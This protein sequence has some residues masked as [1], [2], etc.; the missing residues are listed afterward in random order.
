MPKLVPELSDAA[1]RRLRHRGKKSAV[2]AVGG[3]VGLLLVCKPPP[4]GQDIGARSW[5]LRAK[6]GDKRRDLGLGG[7][8]DVT[9]SQARQR[10]RETK[11]KIWQGIDPVA[12][13]KSLKSALVAE[14]AKAV[15]FSDLSREYIQKKSKEF[16]TAKQVQKLSSHL[17]SYACPFIGR[18][19]VGDIERAHIVRMLEPIWETKNETA[20][21][22]RLHT[23]RILDLAGVKGLRAGD[24]PARW[25]GNLDLTFPARKK[26][27]KTQHYAALP[28]DD[29]PEFW[30]KLKGETSIGAKALQLLILTAARS[31]EARGATWD[32][33]NLKK[34][35]WIIPGERTK[36]GKV[37]TVPLTDETIRLLKTMPKLGDYLFT[38]PKGKPIADVVI[39]RAPKV[40]GYDVTAHGFRATFRTWTQEHTA[41]PEEV[42][43]LALG[44]VN[45]DA[46]RAAYA[47]GELID[48]RRH[49]MADW[50]RFILKGH[51]KNNKVVN[52][53]GRQ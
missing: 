52:I 20:A 49:L 22:V 48:K 30:Q 24:N 18:M 37:H 34:R 9:L 3:V 50:E 16:K 51:L 33:F 35:V 23:E 26:V 45:S 29:L 31:G 2:Y 27:A 28:V 6:V 19:V 43:E 4:V 5:I 11:E 41:Y 25:K 21:R 8:P 7:Y 14:Q 44:H 46:T 40:I 13:R 15:T 42:C 47:R 10:A 39:S 53:G 32:E 38:G 36:S 12:E 1:V 17:E